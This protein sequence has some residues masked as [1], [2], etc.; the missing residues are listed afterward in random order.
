MLGI[1]E[2]FMM[3]KQYTKV[4]SV[5]TELMPNSQDIEHIVVSVLW[6]SQ[7]VS[8]RGG[9]ALGAVSSDCDLLSPPCLISSTTMPSQN[10]SAEQRRIAKRA[11]G[12]A[13]SSSHQPWGEVGEDKRVEWLDALVQQLSTTDNKGIAET[14]NNDRELG[15][16]ILKEKLKTLRYK[17]KVKDTLVTEQ[18]PPTTEDTEER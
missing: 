14:I 12:F 18:S 7:P 6:V 9:L 2:M 17:P 11:A 4:L 10:L 8:L 3:V 1:H 15:F 13:I 5:C 16:T